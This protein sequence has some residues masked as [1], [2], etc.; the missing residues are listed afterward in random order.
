MDVNDIRSYH[1]KPTTPRI[2][3]IYRVQNLACA[4]TA[5]ICTLL[6]N[7]K[8][9]RRAKQEAH[10]YYCAGTVLILCYGHSPRSEED[11][12]YNRAF[13]IEDDPRRLCYRDRNGWHDFDNCEE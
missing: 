5:P 8:S 3:R 10:K 7:Y 13:A 6:N 2:Y 4:L 9:I 11:K 1:A 12:A